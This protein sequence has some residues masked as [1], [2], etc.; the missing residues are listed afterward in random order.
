MRSFGVGTALL[1]RAI[2][3]LIPGR[4]NRR[5]APDPISTRSF[6]TVVIA[7]RP[8]SFTSPSTFSV[9]NS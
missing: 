2:T 8:P 4:L 5:A 6:V 1:R 9:R 7:D 3:S